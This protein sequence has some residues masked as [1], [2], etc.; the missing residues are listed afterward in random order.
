MVLY[1]KSNG[2]KPELE[3]TLTGKP[4]EDPSVAEGVPF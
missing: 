1:Y 2:R 3:R 4:L